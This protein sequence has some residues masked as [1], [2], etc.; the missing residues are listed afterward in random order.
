MRIVFAIIMLCAASACSRVGSDPWASVDYTQ[1]EC[2]TKEA[3]LTTTGCLTGP[4]TDTIADAH[5][6]VSDAEDVG[7]SHNTRTDGPKK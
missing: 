2:G 5:K 6:P 1:A 7:K 4:A 3:I